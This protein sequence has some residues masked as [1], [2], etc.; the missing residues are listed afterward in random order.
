[1]LKI[2]SDLQGDVLNLE[3]NGSIDE[4]A[5]FAEQVG[6]VSAS[7]VHVI[8]R[9]IPR[10]NSVGVKAWIKFFQTVSEKG[11]KLV[12]KECSTAIVEQMN[13]ISNFRCGGEVESVYVPFTCEDCGHK[14]VGLF[15]A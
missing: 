1:M 12:F 2:N 13:L 10:I 8:C 4:N 3:L 7:E 11:A 6:E 9:E 5:Q 15:N 14:L